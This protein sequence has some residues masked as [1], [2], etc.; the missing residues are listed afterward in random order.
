MKRFRAALLGLMLLGPAWCQAQENAAPHLSPQDIAV[1]AATCFTCHGPNGQPPD[2]TPGGIPGLRGRSADSLLQRL[3]AFKAIG[4]E[5]SNANA[6]IMPLL[7][8]GYD[9]AQIEAL[10]Q[11]FARQEN[12]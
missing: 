1:L 3:R 6:T 2:D 9:D 7:M 4:H 10:A 11:W 12:R 8:Q 5:K